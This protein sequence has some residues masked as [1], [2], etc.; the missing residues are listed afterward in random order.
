MWITQNGVKWGAVWRYQP[1]PDDAY[2][3]KFYDLA[4][5][6]SYT[7]A[8]YDYSD[9]GT[10]TIYKFDFNST[11]TYDNTSWSNKG[12]VNCQSNGNNRN[13][14]LTNLVDENPTFL[15]FAN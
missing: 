13:Y 10:A 12:T 14:T 8:F 15:K 4:V 7:F 11:P 2:K 9:P 6:D 5:K 3:N 1:M